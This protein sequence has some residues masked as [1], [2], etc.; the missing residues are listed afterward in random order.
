MNLLDL[1]MD[2]AVDAVVDVLLDEAAH[3]NGGML[4]TL[5]TVWR[6]IK[7]PNSRNRT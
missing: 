6:P 3:E 4:S 7:H 1:V 2:E 5:V